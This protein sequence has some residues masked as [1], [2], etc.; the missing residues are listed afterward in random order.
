MAQGTNEAVAPPPPDLRVA[1]ANERTA[2]AWIRTSLALMAFGFVVA[3]IGL[4]LRGG[5]SEAN[6][7]WLGWIGS[8]FVL[9]GM[10]SGAL[11][12]RRYVRVSKALLEGRVVLPGSGAVLFLSVGVIVMGGVLVTYLLAWG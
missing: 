7:P 12:A 3:R 4:L 1:Q 11:A 9:L 5:P 8:T 2:L 6:G 10:A